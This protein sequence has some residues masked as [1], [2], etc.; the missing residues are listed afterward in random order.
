MF[1]CLLQNWDNKNWLLRKPANSYGLAKSFYTKEISKVTGHSVGHVG[2]I[3][4]ESISQLRKLASKQKMLEKGGRFVI[5]AIR[6]ENIDKNEL[7]AL[8]YP[9][10][11]WMEKEIKSV[12]KNIK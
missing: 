2:V 9:D 1:E 12:N 10:Q 8:S 6:K 5:N 7:M 11:L 3:L 4:H